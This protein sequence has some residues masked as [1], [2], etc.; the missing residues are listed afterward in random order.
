VSFVLKCK[1]CVFAIRYHHFRVIISLAAKFITQKNC[2]HPLPENTIGSLFFSYNMH[3]GKIVRPNAVRQAIPSCFSRKK[4]RKKKRFP[5]SFF[6]RSSKW[7]IENLGSM[8]LRKIE[9]ISM[10]CK[11]KVV[12]AITGWQ[13]DG[14]I[15]QPLTNW[16]GLLGA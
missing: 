16:E 15:A 11:R 5:Y 14:W 6:F 8:E 10:K 7:W 9:N 4:R 12:I 13:T 3:P 2:R 1:Y